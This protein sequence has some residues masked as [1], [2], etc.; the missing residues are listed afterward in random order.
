MRTGQS[1]FSLLKQPGAWI[2]LGMSLAA[3][4]LVV[5]HALV[6]GMVHE[7]DEG[8]AAHMW[9]LLMV[10]QLP[11][12]AYFTIKWMPIRARETL[13]VLVILAMTWLANFAAVFW[14]T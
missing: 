1:N 6:Y 2:P 13:Q 7:V 8:A 14:L 11:F 3:L 10:G 5:G 4:A 9:Q 12:L